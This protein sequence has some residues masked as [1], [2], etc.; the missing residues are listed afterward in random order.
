MTYRML[1]D[2]KVAFNDI[3][4]ERLTGL[5]MFMIGST[6]DYAALGVVVSFE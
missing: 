5:I 6:T 2:M 3:D 4:E 1:T